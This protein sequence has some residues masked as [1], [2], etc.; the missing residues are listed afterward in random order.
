MLMAINDL[1]QTVNGYQPHRRMPRDCTA[2]AFFY[3]AQPQ[4]V[5][6]MPLDS[7]CV[8]SAGANT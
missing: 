6:R 1:I 5:I 8:E 4:C 3:V 2:I 7:M